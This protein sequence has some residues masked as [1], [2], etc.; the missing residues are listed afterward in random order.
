MKLSRRQLSAVIA[1][2]N[3][4]DGFTL[5]LPLCEAGQVTSDML[6]S[7][8]YG[9]VHA[10]TMNALVAKGV[11]TVDSTGVI[12]TPTAVA[13]LLGEFADGSKAISVLRQAASLV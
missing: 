7:V 12:Y 1:L 11:F 8:G 13:R 2:S 6:A 3:E 10:N 9:G 5:A 4:T